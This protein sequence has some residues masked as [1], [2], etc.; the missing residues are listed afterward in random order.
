MWFRKLKTFIWGSGLKRPAPQLNVHGGSAAANRG[1]DFVKIRDIYEFK[2]L[3]P[4]S[5]IKADIL[6]LEKTTLE[7]EKTVLED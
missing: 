2:L 5:E 3:H 4:L 7:L 1:A 6:A